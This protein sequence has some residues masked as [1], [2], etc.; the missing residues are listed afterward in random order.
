MIQQEEGPRRGG[1]QLLAARA[2]A[3]FGILLALLG[4]LSV[5]ISFEFLG[6][7]LG[8]TGYA[9]GSRRLGTTAI[10]L[11]MLMLLLVLAISRGYVP[12]IDPTY[13]GVF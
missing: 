13:P 12:G 10:V 7:V 1:I 2:L 4:A 8:I 6:I 11:S 3:L 5:E 9:L